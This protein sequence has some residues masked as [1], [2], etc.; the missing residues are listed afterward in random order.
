VTGAVV[1][2][3]GDSLPL[4]DVSAKALAATGRATGNDLIAAT[5]AGVVASVAF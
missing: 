4:A 3:A 1:S 2:T 5:A